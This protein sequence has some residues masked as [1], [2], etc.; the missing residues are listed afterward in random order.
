MKTYGWAGK[1]LRV[2]LTRKKITIEPT[3][4]YAIDFLGGKGVNA[5][6]LFD[7]VPPEVK[8]FDPENRI[9]FGT[10]PLTG[11]L[12]PSAARCNVTTKS[13]LTGIFGDANVGAYWGPE[14]KF[15]GYDHIVIYGRSEKPVYLWI[16]NDEVEIRDAS[17][18]WG[19]DTFETQEIIKKELGDPEIQIMCIGPAGEKKVRFANIVTGTSDSASRTGV[20][21]VMGS[22]N[23][24]AIAVRG[25][26][27]INIAKPDEFENICYEI[28]EAIKK[29]PIWQAFGI[30]M[31]DAFK[32]YIASGTIA[33]GNKD[34]R[35]PP[36]FDME[37]FIKKMDEFTEKYKVRNVG[38]F[39]CPLRCQA[40]FHV[41]GIGSAK[42]TCER[43]QQALTHSKV[44]DFEFNLQCFIL[45]QK[46]GM[47]LY[48]ATATIA[49]IIDLFKKG[50]KTKRDTG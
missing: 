44:L 5:K 21:A 1:I 30:S 4:K 41:P 2:D 15:A 26:K 38:C 13:P 22:K 49:F 25:T 20:G 28:R 33:Y 48:S 34:P 12:A 37:T 24:K 8:P 43:W 18:L 27:G 32:M 6:I 19:K 50:N 11:T 42:L 23:L 39:S 9:I 46:Y 16:N 40:L 14:L 35:V 10:G 17:H 29:S 45:V 31:S 47:D 36:G 7:E 3:M